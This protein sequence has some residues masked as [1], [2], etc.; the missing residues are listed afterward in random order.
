MTICDV[1]PF[2]INSRANSSQEWGYDRGLSKEKE[3]DLGG[4]NIDE[5]ITWVRSKRFQEEFDK[6]LNS[7][8][9]EREE[10]LEFI[11]FNQLLE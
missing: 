10:E 5:P 11:Y 4:L 9:D 7:L 3:F 6:R 8:M 1:A 2:E